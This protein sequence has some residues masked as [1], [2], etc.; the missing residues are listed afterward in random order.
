MHQRIYN[1]H[2]KAGLA[3]GREATCGTKID[4]K[5][6]GTAEKSAR[7]MW[8]KT[9]KEFDHYPCAWCKGWHIGRAMTEE[10]IERFM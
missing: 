6:E 4:Y 8:D 3:Y 7:A 10:E 9:G 2:I 1:T 5:S